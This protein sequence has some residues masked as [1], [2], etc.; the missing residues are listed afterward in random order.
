MSVNLGAAKAK[1]EVQA[2]KKKA[3]TVHWSSAHFCCKESDKKA[4]LHVERPPATTACQLQVDY[5]TSDGTA[6]EGADYIA[7]SGTLT[8]APGELTQELV[9]VVLEDAEAEE[10]EHFFVMLGEVKC[11][12]DVQTAQDPVAKVT[13][14]D[15]TGEPVIGFSETLTLDTKNGV[16]L[17]TVSEECGSVFIKVHR[18]GGADTEVKCLFETKSESAS[19]G[20]DYEA[21]YE[22]N[23]TPL[24]FDAHEL[25]K[26][27]EIKIIDDELYEKDELFHVLLKDPQGA[28]IDTHMC[29]VQIT[30]DDA[31]KKTTDLLVKH[32]QINWD[33]MD[34]GGSAYVKQFRDALEWPEGGGAVVMHVLTVPWKLVFAFVPP[35]SMMGGWLCFCLA[36]GM[37]GLVT[38][39]IGDLASHM[40]CAFGLKASVTAITFV[41]LGTSLPD[42][43]ASK[44]AA[45]GDSNAD[46]AVG[47]V[48]GSNS[49]NVFL[50]LGLPWLIAAVQW[51]IE[52]ATPVWRAR[53]LAMDFVGNADIVANNPGGAFVVPAGTLGFSVTIFSLCA[54]MCLVVICVRRAR[55]GYELGG[56][57]ASPTAAV[58]VLLWVYYVSMSTL[59]AYDAFSKSGLNWAWYT[60]FGGGGAVML[61]ALVLMLSLKRPM[62]VHPVSP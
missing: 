7:Q 59:Q 33:A 31:V 21:T 38:A 52:G 4:V 35:P 12:V 36:L 5:S 50:G 44:S 58:F 47:N 61:L 11:E 43:F 10:N 46:S 19:P 49:V 6:H 53:V 15:T 20:N 16:P 28:T 55:L 40:G 60:L 14:I 34:D 24:V 8:F 29:K 22:S 25:Q 62:I 27:V 17:Y 18:K 30:N 37:I 48:T 3:E 57:K 45:I 42:T 51:K 41:A 1:L 26:V 13:V 9:I 2:Q 23:P 54:V 39:L 56:D 32:L